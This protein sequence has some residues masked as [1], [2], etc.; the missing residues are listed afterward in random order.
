MRRQHPRLGGRD[1]P[2]DPR[3]AASPADP[4]QRAGDPA[5]LR[6]G[7]AQSRA[8]RPASRRPRT[9]GRAAARHLADRRG[10]PDEAGR[11]RPGQLAP[12]RR[13]MHRSGP[14]DRGFP[15]WGSGIPCRPARP[16]RHSA[17]A[18]RDGDCRGEFAWTTAR[19]GGRKGTC[20]PGLE[21]WLAGLGVEVRANP[22]RRPQDN[23]VV[24]RSQGTG[25]RW[26]E[27]HRAGLGGANSRRPSMPWT[28]GN[29]SPTRTTAEPAAWP[30]IRAWSIRAAPTTNPERSNVG[31]WI[32]G[33]GPAGRLCRASASGPKRDGL[34]LQPELLRRQDIRRAGGACEVRSP[35]ATLAV[36]G[37]RGSPAESA[38]GVGDQCGEHPRADGGPAARS[39]RSERRGKTRCRGF[40]GPT[41]CRD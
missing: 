22:P 10:R 37:R 41:R 40:S 6:P 35:A 26:A 25:K 31:P 34:G 19:R 24:E 27:P 21:L 12:G 8:R 9:P 36:P 33:P 4:A 5:G 20:P 32:E 3:R 29:A 2:G 14:G 30:P 11:H 1:H 28:V 7:R 17:A 23:G 18:S 38:E 13:R 16:R 15:P 39:L